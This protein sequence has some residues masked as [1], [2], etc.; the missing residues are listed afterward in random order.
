MSWGGLPFYIYCIEA[1][2]YDAL[3]SGAMRE[4]LNAGYTLS[5]PD[6]WVRRFVN[7]GMSQN[8]NST[9][10]VFALLDITDYC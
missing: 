3:M 4:E 10:L 1:E 6:H 9:R 2:E 5:V 7:D 8:E